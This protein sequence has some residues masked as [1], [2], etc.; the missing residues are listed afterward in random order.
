M[1]NTAN[2]VNASEKTAHKYGSQGDKYWAN[3]DS[4]AIFVDN[5][6]SHPDN[7]EHQ[8][9]NCN[10]KDGDKNPEFF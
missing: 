10:Q 2:I 3:N 5:S 6:I 4:F 8:E 9:G 7:W 1:G